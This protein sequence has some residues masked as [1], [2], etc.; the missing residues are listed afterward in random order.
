MNPT[1]TPKGTAAGRAYTALCNEMPMNT[2]GVQKRKRICRPQLH[3]ASSA[4]HPD[5]TPITP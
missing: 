1:T 2:S 4:L 3:G 5:P